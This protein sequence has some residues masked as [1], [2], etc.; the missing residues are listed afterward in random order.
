VS[1]CLKDLLSEKKIQ[2]TGYARV[3]NCMHARIKVPWLQL[4]SYIHAYGG[5][6]VHAHTGQ[7]N[8]VLKPKALFPRI[9]LAGGHDD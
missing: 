1:L 7:Q 2:F 3:I 9:A 6:R 8:E 5:G 4:S